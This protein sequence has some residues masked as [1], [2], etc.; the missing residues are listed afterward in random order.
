MNQ[1]IPNRFYQHEASGRKVSLYGAA[2]WAGE[3]DKGQWLILQNGYSILWQDGTIG[4]PHGHNGGKSFATPQEAEA[5]LAT[6]KFNGFAAMANV[7]VIVDF[8]AI[9]TELARKAYGNKSQI[10][11]ECKGAVMV[12]VLS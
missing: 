7:E 1:V 10:A 6:T 8:H 11:K 3:A 4:V 2:P 9:A 12:H 5:F